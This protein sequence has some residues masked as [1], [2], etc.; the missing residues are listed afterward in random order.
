MKALV[1]YKIWIALV[2]VVLVSW[3]VSGFDEEPQQSTSKRARSSASTVRKSPTAKADQRDPAEA[4]A[5]IARGFK[6]RDA[7]DKMSDDPFVTASFEP[8]PPPPPPPPKP[9]APPLNFKYL[10]V[11]RDGDDGRNA[12]TANADGAD[13]SPKER[14][15]FLDSGGQL[16]IARKGDTLAGQY[17]V[18]EIGDT[19]MQFE[20]LPLAE[21]Q[22]L[23]F[24]R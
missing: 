16:L 15:V 23:N 2:A 10:G 19:S 6:P 12:G 20:Y 11:L 24:G 13:A 21:R 1:K 3:W 9:V 18:L 14:A 7:M 8:P 22:T 5:L 4:L 17:R